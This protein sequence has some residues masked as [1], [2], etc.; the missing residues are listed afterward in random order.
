[1][2]RKQHTASKINIVGALASSIAAT[3]FLVGF[4]VYF[5]L[6]EQTG[7]PNLTADTHAQL[8]FMM[9]H[10]DF[11][12]TWY[13]IIYLVFGVCLVILIPILH[14]HL[15][16]KKNFLSESASVF[17][18]IWTGLVFCCGL[19]IHVGISQ[20]ID[21]YA[22][23]QAQALTLWIVIYSILEGLDGGNELVGGLWIL[24]V[25]ITALHQNR[26]SIW[27]GC[28]GIFVGITGVLTSLPNMEIFALLFGL[29]SI[30]WFG[31]VS[32]CMLN[33]K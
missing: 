1:M 24:L 30:V 18:L 8:Q 32:V 4:A 11:L 5:I 23:H 29:G 22:H 20:I 33:R 31:G 9:Q 2:S 27:L 12:R 3:C 10:R 14:H 17:G 7:Y 28:T 19:L 15:A 26:F 13:A 6:L 21:I 25:S 16:C